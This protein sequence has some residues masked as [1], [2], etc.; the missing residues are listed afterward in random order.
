LG[1][2]VFRFAGACFPRDQTG[3]QDSLTR[4]QRM[5][6]KFSSDDAI[7]SVSGSMAFFSW[8]ICE[9][10][11]L[12]KAL[13]NLETSILA[14]KLDS[15]PITKPV[16]VAGLAR[17]GST[18]L[19]EILAESPGVVSQRYKDFPPV[20]T[21]YAWN[22]LLSYMQS[23][24]AE[25][26]ERAHKDGILVTMDSP[27][28]ME[29]PLWMSFF[30]GLHDPQQTNVIEPNCDDR[31]FSRFYAAHIRKLL[32]VRGATRYL[33]KANYQVT[34]LEYLLKLF[35]DARFV[36]PVREPAAHIASLIKQQTLFSRGQAANPRARDHLRRVGHYEFGLDRSPINTGDSLATRKIV[37]AWEAGDELG[38][39]IIYWNT[40]H[41][42]LLERIAVNSQLAAAVRFVIFEQLCAEPQQQLEAIT[43]H[44]GLDTNYTFISRAAERIQMPTY[45]KSGFSDLELVSIAQGTGATMDRIRALT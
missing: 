35:P 33:A 40:L 41:N 16:Y 7:F 5:A 28:A 2:F 22:K 25:P 20:F 23:G 32:A 18:L 14:D 13:G 15:I 36:L 44:C 8:L 19:L 1:V 39:W 12:W 3:L 30:P 17:S 34:R 21:P 27:E 6:S 9:H 26:T 24:P 10:P 11:G 38:G 42:Y 29:E 4:L 31:G 43:Q 45:Y 37:S